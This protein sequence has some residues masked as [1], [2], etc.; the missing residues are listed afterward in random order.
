M[1][2][3]TLLDQLALTSSSVRWV[4]WASNS[5]VIHVSSLM[6]V[7][8]VLQMPHFFHLVCVHAHVLAV[9]IVSVRSPPTCLHTIHPVLHGFHAA[10]LGWLRCLLLLHHVV[11]LTTLR[12]MLKFP[13][14]V[15]TA[16]PIL[17]TAGGQCLAAINGHYVTRDLFG[18]I[19]MKRETDRSYDRT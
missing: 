3:S 2:S 6:R 8:C 9:S 12:V 15:T 13:V 4:D 18:A 17:L 16:V 19:L 10:A 14:H 7:S 11:E 5:W 1:Q